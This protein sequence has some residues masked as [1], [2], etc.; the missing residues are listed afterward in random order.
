MYCTSYVYTVLVY[1]YVVQY[2]SCAQATVRRTRRAASTGEFWWPL[3][4]SSSRYCCSPASSSWSFCTER[5]PAY[6]SI[7]FSVLLH[8]RNSIWDYQ[9]MYSSH[10]MS[11]VLYILSHNI[12]ENSKSVRQTSL[13]C[14]LRTF[15]QLKSQNM[16]CNYAS[17]SS[18]LC[19]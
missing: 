19:S 12:R 16:L 10:I 8:I 5:K 14:R 1:P 3:W 9:I 11:Y 2:I 13:I 18:N 7:A 15:M 6:Q 17:K 4:L